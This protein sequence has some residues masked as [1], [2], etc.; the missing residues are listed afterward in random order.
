[1]IHPRYGVGK[2]YE[3]KLNQAFDSLDIRK[4]T[5]GIDLADGKAKAEKVQRVS[6]RVVC[7]LLRE[8]KKREVRRIFEA[9]NYEVLHLTRVAFGPILIG[10]LMPGYGRFLTST[11]VIQLKQAT[12]MMPAPK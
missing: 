2:W 6:R 3:V 9:L 1:M 12:Q 5:Q 11:E 8:G 4:L 7:I 10:R